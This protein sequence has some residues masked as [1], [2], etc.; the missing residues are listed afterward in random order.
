M[1]ASECGGSDPLG[2][3][4]TL[5]YKVKRTSRL[6]GISEPAGGGTGS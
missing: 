5:A 4:L 2:P 6:T 3:F 1:L